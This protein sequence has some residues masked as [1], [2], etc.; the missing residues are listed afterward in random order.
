LSNVSVSSCA[1]K[2]IGAPPVEIEAA[3]A[4]VSLPPS[5]MEHFDKASILPV[6]VA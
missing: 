1:I 3:C 4:I 5:D 2:K 6:V